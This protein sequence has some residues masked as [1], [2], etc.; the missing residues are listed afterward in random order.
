MK[1]KGYEF[2][3]GFGVDSGLCW[4]GDPCYSVTPDAKNHPAKTWEEFCKI[5]KSD[6]THVFNQGICVST[7]WGDGVYPVYAKIVNGR[8]K[9]VIIDFT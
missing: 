8:V 4:I 3:G 7:G 2:V 5:I 6:N 1:I 9:R